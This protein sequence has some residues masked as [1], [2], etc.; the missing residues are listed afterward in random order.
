MCIIERKRNYKSDYMRMADIKK[1]KCFT[2]SKFNMNS[3]VKNTLFLPSNDIMQHI[4]V[5][6]DVLN[7]NGKILGS[8]H[9]F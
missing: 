2:T 7:N 1:K 4:T 6:V 9:R 8:K 5:F 3:V